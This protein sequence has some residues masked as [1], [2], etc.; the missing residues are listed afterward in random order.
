[1][2]QSNFNR[3]YTQ[4]NGGTLDGSQLS[5]TSDLVD[6]DHHDAGAA[7]GDGSPIQQH[8]KPRAGSEFDIR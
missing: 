2:V 7:H 4:L 6:D 5:V 3:A 1:M 8:E